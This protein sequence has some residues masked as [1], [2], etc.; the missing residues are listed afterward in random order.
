[1]LENMLADELHR[2]VKQRLD[3][4]ESPSLEDATA[5]FM[6]YRLAIVVGESEASDIS[7][8][9][10]L[11]TTVALA[12]RVFLGGVAVAGPL[13]VPLVSKVVRATSLRE[14][15]KI[16]GATDDCANLDGL[17]Q[18]LI[19]QTT[20]RRPSGFCVRV[21]YSDWRGGV[22]HRDGLFERSSEPIMPLA[23]MLGAALAVSEAFSAVQGQTSLPGRRSVG[24]SLWEPAQQNWLAYQPGAPRLQFLPSQLWLIGLGH[25]GQAYL[26][27]LGLLPYR[28]PQALRLVLQDFDTITPST[29]ST[30]ILSGVSMVGQKKTRAMA[31]WAEARGFQAEIVERRFAADFRRQADE[32]GVALSGI[33]NAIGRR[34]LD[35]VGFHLV[36]EAGLGRGHEDFRSLRIHTLPSK[37]NA[38][39]IWKASP[40]RQG[41]SERPAYQNLLNSKLLDQCGVTLL[42]GKAVG[43]PFVGAVAA[44]LVLSELLRFLHGG[45]LHSLVDVDLNSVDHRSALTTEIDFAGLNPGYVA[46]L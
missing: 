12:R 2:L 23:P 5:V 21:V 20:A 44:T 11:L 26:W 45:T 30:S 3:S 39:D 1:M 22:T 15:I 9:D 35:Q 34:A 32:P 37:R 8:Q 16:L 28:D 14:A 4:G 7:A 10:A 25:L 38:A 17:P 43:A 42:A 24:M 19:G 6:A 29:E 41:A 27:G 46:L 18:V 33:D 36:I 40:P 31:A 13:D